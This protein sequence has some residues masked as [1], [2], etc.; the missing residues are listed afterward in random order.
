[1]KTLKQLIESKKIKKLAAVSPDQT[2]LQAL[3]IMAEFD[4]GALLVLDGDHLAGVFSE[5][6][7]ARKVILQGKGSRQT[8]VSEVMTGKVVYVKQNSTIE[9]CMAI[10][11]EKHIRHLPVLDD[12]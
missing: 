12:N 9:E 4:V 5:R 3:E 6:D 7:Y 11:T 10:M 8:K 2:V 1:M